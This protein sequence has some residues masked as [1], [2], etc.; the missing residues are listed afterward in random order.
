MTAPENDWLSRYLEPHKIV[1]P[2]PVDSSL[3]PIEVRKHTMLVHIP[4]ELLMDEGLIPDTRPPV[5]IP[6]RRRIRWAA[7]DRIHRARLRVGSWIAGK[8]LDR[9]DDE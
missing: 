7:Q 3:P 6:W 1:S 5:H 8:D 2:P 9:W 4:E